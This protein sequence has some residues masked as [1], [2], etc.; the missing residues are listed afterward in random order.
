M[1][2]RAAWSGIPAYPHVDWLKTSIRMRDLDGMYRRL[3]EA[4]ER[5]ATLEERLRSRENDDD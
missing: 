2:A 5:I 3:Q 1:P 4:E